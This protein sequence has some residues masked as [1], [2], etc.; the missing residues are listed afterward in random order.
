MKSVGLKNKEQSFHLFFG[1]KN[2]VNSA[3]N[4]ISWSTIHSN[5]YNFFQDEFFP[6]HTIPYYHII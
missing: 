5:V 6:Y 4:N 2:S 3:N 1:L